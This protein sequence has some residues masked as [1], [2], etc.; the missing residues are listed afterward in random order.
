[1]KKILTTPAGV[2]GPYASIEAMGDCYIADGIRLPYLVVG[3]GDVSDYA[4][5]EAPGPAVPAAITMRQA[6]LVLLGAGLLDDVD[7]AIAAIPDATTRR[8]AQ[9]EWEFSNELRRDNSF[10]ALLAPA[11]GLDA[12]AI[13]A[14]FIAGAGL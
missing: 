6:R 14:L 5:P 4:E 3:V 10:V 9:I 11:L 12:A 1:M 7:G 13:D 2:F 8:A